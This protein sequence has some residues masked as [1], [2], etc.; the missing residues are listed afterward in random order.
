MLSGYVLTHARLG[1]AHPSH[2]DAPLAYVRKRCA[3]I[4]PLYAL[5]VLLSAILRMAQGRALPPLWVLA[6][7]S[8]LLQVT[9]SPHALV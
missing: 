4:V 2:V 6:L 1:S 9:R 3:T 5:G 7:Q 8:F